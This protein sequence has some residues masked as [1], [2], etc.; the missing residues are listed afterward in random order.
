LLTEHRDGLDQLRSK[1]TD[2]GTPYASVLDAVCATLPPVATG[3]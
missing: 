2:F 1:L 3:G